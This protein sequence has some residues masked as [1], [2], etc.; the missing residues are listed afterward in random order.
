M[1]KNQLLE[2]Q[3]LQISLCL[4]I[5]HNN[6]L[7][8]ILC[9]GEKLSGEAFYIGD[10]E[11]LE[12]LAKQIGVA[13]ANALLLRNLEGMVRDRTLD[14]SAANQQLQRLNHQLEEISAA[15]SEFVSIASH[16]LKTPL[17]IIKSILSMLVS[18]DFGKLTA[19]QKNY[20]AR[21][22]LNTERLIKLV[23]DILNISKIEAGKVQLTMSNV[24]LDS[25][26]EEV[27]KNYSD[28][29]KNKGLKIILEKTDI[30]TIKAD[31]EQIEQAIANL[32]DNAIKYTEQGEVKIWFEKE[33]GAVVFKIKDTGT[34]M[35]KDEMKTLFEKF[36]RGKSGERLYTGGT[37]I[38]LYTARRIIEVHGGRIWAKSEGLGKGSL[39][40]FSLPLE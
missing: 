37:G 13:L 11:I 19:E 40:A 1:A 23:K 29:A 12:I 9:L 5:S 20:L 18:G 31:R 26:A 15:K 7:I 36:I 21:A 33:N 10:I 32:L 8:G 34:G 38:G 3:K 16:Q 22:S 30:P 17:T 35:T 14:L 24:H 2:M 39:F 6:K 28:I 4:P 27:I 25:L